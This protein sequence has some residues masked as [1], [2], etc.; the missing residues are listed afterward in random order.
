MSLEPE[1]CGS[2]SPFWHWPAVQRCT[3]R[4]TSLSLGDI[5]CKPDLFASQGSWEHER[6]CGWEPGTAGLGQLV[7]LGYQQ[8]RLVSEPASQDCACSPSSPV[9]QAPSWARGCADSGSSPL[10]PLQWAQSSDRPV[11]FPVAQPML[12]SSWLWAGP[13]LDASDSR[14]AGNENKMALGCKQQIGVGLGSQQQECENKI[15]IE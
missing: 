12:D 3:N 15:L 1:R 5:M 14:C 4:L 8:G 7:T 10:C 2:E 9:Y 6:W 11:S 13:V